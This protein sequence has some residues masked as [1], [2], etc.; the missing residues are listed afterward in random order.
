MPSLDRAGTNI[1]YKV[2]PNAGGQPP[3]LLSHGFGASSAMW[4]P[5]RAALAAGRPVITWDMRG[6][7]RSDSPADPAEYTHAAC[8]ADMAALLDAV[9][10]EQAVAG[11]LSLGGFLSLAFCLQL[12]AR[13]AALVLCDTGPGF[14]SDDARQRWNSRALA[15]ADRLERDGLGVFGDGSGPTAPGHRSASGLAMA[16]RGMLAQSSS[17]VIDGLASIRVPTLVLTGGRD[18]AFLGAADY[19]AAK[20]PGAQKVVI[21]GAGHMCNIDQPALFNEAVLAF[22]NSLH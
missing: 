7:G 21:P 4:Q 2:T 20:I 18:E 22:L 5:N 3:L 19:V 14:R 12:P 8:V 10:A 15:T 9:G 16:A 13:V 6:H 1:Y 11:G 17:E